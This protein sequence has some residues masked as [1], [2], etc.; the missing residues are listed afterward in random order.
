M[1]ISPA[2]P[3]V[4]KELRQYKTQEERIEEYK[5][6]RRGSVKC[7]ACGEPTDHYGYC[8]SCKEEIQ[9]RIRKR[10]MAF[11]ESPANLYKGEY[12]VIDIT[13]L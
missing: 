5:A 2:S 11:E 9:G 8:A 6:M 7:L 13:E 3:D 12:V 10:K 4:L 1:S